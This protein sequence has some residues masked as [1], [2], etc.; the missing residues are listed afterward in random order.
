MHIGHDHGGG[1]GGGA[2]NSAFMA[3]ESIDDAALFSFKVKAFFI[4]LAIAL[5]GGMLPLKARDMERVCS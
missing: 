2:V 4:M 3:D 5:V 1:G